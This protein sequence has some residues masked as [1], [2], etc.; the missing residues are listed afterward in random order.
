[1]SST[2][3]CPSNSPHTVKEYQ[4]DPKV[5]S[6]AGVEVGASEQPLSEEGHAATVQLAH[7]QGDLQGMPIIFLCSMDEEQ[8]QIPI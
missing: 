1:M 2:H 7:A 6:V 4:I 3:D 5:D 8:H